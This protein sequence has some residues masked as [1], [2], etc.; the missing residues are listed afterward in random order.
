MGISGIVAEFNP[1]HNGHKYLIDCAK[2]NGNTVVC[3]IS[4]NFVQRGDTAIVPKFVRAKM[5]LECGADIVVELQTPWAMS[6]AQNFAFGALSHLLALGVDTLYFGSESG[7]LDELL[8]VSKVLSS[9]KYNQLI[10]TRIGSNL[11]FATLRSEIV[12]EI[13]GYNT[14][15]LEN[16]NDTLAIEYISASK[17]LGANLKFVPVKRVGAGH[18]D[19]SSYGDFTNATLLRKAVKDKQHEFLY[20]YM[21]EC[22]A[23]LLLSS[24]VSSIEKLDTAIIS[25]LK[26]CDKRE[27]LSLPD[28]SEGIENLLY[29][30]IRT[31]NGYFELVD[32]L[33]TKRY[34]HAR[35]RRLVLSAFLGIDK[36]YFGTE[37]PYVRIL[38]FKKDSFIN[39]ANSNIKP[40]ITRVSQIKELNE[41]AREIFDLENKINEIY[42]L[43][44]DRP[45]QFINENTQKIIIK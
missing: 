33:K 17:K 32:T 45:E 44:L 5:A 12:S 9:D 42:S 29:N 26:L 22:C 41:S 36:K 11:T 16:P 1:L 4:G 34:T 19:N 31:A 35:L 18:N 39:I 6:T 15:V 7:N 14:T 28:I 24:P 37:P 3:V 10:S 8:A 30:G 23:K 20:K 27:F 21:P 2:S 38:S 43:S 13:L 25:R 40:I